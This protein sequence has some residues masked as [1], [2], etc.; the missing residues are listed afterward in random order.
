M[1]LLD[2]D[3][4]SNLLKRAPS[5][6]LEVKLASIPPEQQFTSSITL[7]ELVYG[8][9]RLGE[10]ASKF[11]AQL[12]KAILPNLPVLPFDATA[13]SIYGA[14]RAQ[15]EALGKPLGDADLRIAAIALAR[16]LTVVT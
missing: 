8:A 4:L 3:I 11:L 15:M 12:D 10:R 6:T 16:G 5:S 2:T 14:L 7:G 9:H 1:Y 13:A